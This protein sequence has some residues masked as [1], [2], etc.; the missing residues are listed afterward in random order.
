LI[1]PET[2]AARFRFYERRR[3]ERISKWWTDGDGYVHI[4]LT[5]GYEAVIDSIDRALAEQCVWAA[6]PTRG[7]IVYAKAYV[8]QFMRD[9]WSAK[10]VA[11]HQ[12]IL[13]VT[14]GQEVDH[15]N[16]NG[17][18]CRRQNIRIATRSQNGM[19]RVWPK[20]TKSPYRGVSPSGRK[21][22][23]AIQ[24]NYKIQYLGV[25]DT[26]EAAAHAYNL[27]ALQRHG[28]FAVLNEI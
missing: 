17:L 5:Q 22:V 23:A 4:P 20:G 15:K 12:L 10:I 2:T 19:N 16:R 18:D 13:Q 9:R 7:G 11:L 1:H 25:F 3:L 6:I 8:R 26:A 24:V 27:A 28:E 21:W 14:P